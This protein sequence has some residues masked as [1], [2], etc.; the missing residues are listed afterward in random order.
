MSSMNPC[1]PQGHTRQI[2]HRIELPTVR[3]FRHMVC[4][5]SAVS[6]PCSK[7]V[8]EVSTPNTAQPPPPHRLEGGPL[9]VLPR[10]VAQRLLPRAKLEARIAQLQDL[11]R[12]VHQR[13]Q[14]GSV[15]MVGCRGS[16][17]RQQAGMPAA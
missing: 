10:L 6:P 7:S 13:G 15:G 4:K 3:L 14:G 2:V 9:P 11:P 12:V 8:A 16:Q 5:S 1:A 17:Q